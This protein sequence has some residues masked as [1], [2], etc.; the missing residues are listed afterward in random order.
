[1]RLKRV[2]EDL[3][4]YSSTI[5]ACEKAFQ[6]P[7][8]L[9]LLADCSATFLELDPGLSVRGAFFHGLERFEV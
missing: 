8:A 2:E 9:R 1:M 4:T 7:E 5:S 3:I 6:W